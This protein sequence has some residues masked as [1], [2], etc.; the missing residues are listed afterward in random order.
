VRSCSWSP[1]RQIYFPTRAVVSLLAVLPDGTSVKAALVGREGVVGLP[2]LLT[3]ACSAER[4]ARRRLE[5]GLEEGEI[6]FFIKDVRA[7]PACR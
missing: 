1:K 3:T 4:S 5:P 6:P 2:A 7:S